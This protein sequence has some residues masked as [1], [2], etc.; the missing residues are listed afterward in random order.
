MWGVMKTSVIMDVDSVDQWQISVWSTSTKKSLVALMST[1]DSQRLYNKKD[2]FLNSEK[3]KF[4]FIFQNFEF[5]RY[6]WNK[7][8]Y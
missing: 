2:V 7:N 5:L 4:L 6:F 3:M 1:V 8:L